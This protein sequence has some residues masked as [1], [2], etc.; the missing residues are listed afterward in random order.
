MPQIQLIND[1]LTANDWYIQEPILR[2]DSLVYW[3]TDSAIYTRD[4]LKIALSYLK[5]DSLWQL[6]QTTDTLTKVKQKKGVVRKKNKEKEEKPVSLTFTHNI[7]KALEVYDTLQLTFNEPI[8]TFSRDSIHLFTVKDT[9]ET[10]MD[11]NVL[12]HDSV[13]ARIA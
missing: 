7:N 11:F 9:I 13:C 10:P 1:S 12:F 3:I 5:T 4:T 8:R 2:A 6:E